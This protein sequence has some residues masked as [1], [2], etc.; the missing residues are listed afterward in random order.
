M[1]FTSFSDRFCFAVIHKR[2]HERYHE[3]IIKSH[4]CRPPPVAGIIN[5]GCIVLSSNKKLMID[6]RTLPVCGEQILAIEK[7]HIQ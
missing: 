7:H 3:I 1:K 2:Y 5:P 6:N 4:N